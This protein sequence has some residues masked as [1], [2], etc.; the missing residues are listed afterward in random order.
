MTLAPA[1]RQPSFPE[2]PGDNKPLP[3]GGY[4]WTYDAELNSVDL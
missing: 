2:N 3:E 1:P 4:V